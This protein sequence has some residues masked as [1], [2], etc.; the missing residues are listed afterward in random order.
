MYIYSIQ[1]AQWQEYHTHILNTNF[2]G[3]GVTEGQLICCAIQFLTAYYGPQIWIPEFAFGYSARAL[4]LGFFSS[5]VVVL[6]LSNVKTV[7]SKSNHKFIAM[8][9]LVP[10][11]TLVFSGA[12]FAFSSQKHLVSNSIFLL[13]LY[14]SIPR[15]SNLTGNSRA[16]PHRTNTCPKL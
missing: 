16:P 11:F 2:A 4:L 6:I 8:L 13:D 12:V 9:Q 3:V 15:P 7:L 1:L 10:L 14:S 5:I